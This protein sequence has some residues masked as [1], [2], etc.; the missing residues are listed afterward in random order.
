MEKSLINIVKLFILQPK[1]AWEKVSADYKAEG[2]ADAQADEQADAQADAQADGKAD[3][4]ADAQAD[5]KAEAQAA[6]PG[7]VQAEEQTGIKKFIISYLLPLGLIPAIA[8]FIGS[9]IIGYTILGYR[10]HSLSHGIS[11]AVISLLTTLFG[12]FITGF[13]IQKLGPNFKTSLSLE[14]AVKLVGYSYTPLLVA[15]IFNLFPALSIIILLAGIYSLYVLYIGL[16]PMTAVPE[17]NITGYFITTVVVTVVIYVVLGIILGG[18]AA[19]I[20]Y[21]AYHSLI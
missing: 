8:T 2:Q 11:G 13:V 18:I 5:G 3:A 14:K 19:T 4:Q 9:G 12:V 7:G 6:V 20:G 10:V 1:V 16:K 15:G 17:E 21:G